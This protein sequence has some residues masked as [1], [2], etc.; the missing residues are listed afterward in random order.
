VDAAS[1][2][3]KKKLD[4]VRKYSKSTHFCNLFLHNCWKVVCDRQASGILGST[5]ICSSYDTSYAS[6]RRTIGY[7][8]TVLKLT[9]AYSYSNE[10]KFV[11]Y[12][13]RT[14]TVCDWREEGPTPRWALSM[15]RLISLK[16]SGIKQELRKRL[17]V[18]LGPL[19]EDSR[20]DRQFGLGKVLV[21]SYK[22]RLLFQ[23]KQ[24]R[25]GSVNK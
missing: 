25:T 13:F 17:S 14:V 11:T 12:L 7:D 22:Y 9:S 20:Q 1:W 2:P 24:C 16:G 18:L 21:Q 4:T 6:I 15:W 3:S 19:Y 23:K 8:K 5:D 10:P